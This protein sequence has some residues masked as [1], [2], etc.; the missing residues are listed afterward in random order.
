MAQS[1]DQWVSMIDNINKRV[2]ESIRWFAITMVLLQFSIVMLRYLFGITF[3]FLS[4]AVL[5]MHAAMFMI[6]AGYTMLVDG[7]VRVDIFYASFSA[8]KRAMINL[9]GHLVFLLPMCVMI[10]LMSW[11][12]VFNSWKI[13]EGPI[14]VG[15]IPASF[16]LKTIIPVFCFLLVIQA[17]AA[18]SRDVLLIVRGSDVQQERSN[19]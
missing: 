18:I 2:G 6:G 14:S 19:A 7:H 13:L 5:Y 12:F 17:I 9:F 3:I 16:L 11:K 8:R 15:G 1:H 4:E 10:A